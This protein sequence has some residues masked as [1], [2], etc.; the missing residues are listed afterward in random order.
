MEEWRSAE[1]VVG[2]A[3]IFVARKDDDMRGERGHN[4]R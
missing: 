3:R 4:N 1:E 2:Q